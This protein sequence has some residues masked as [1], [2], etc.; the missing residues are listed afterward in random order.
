MADDRPYHKSHARPA[1]EEVDVRFV[2]PLPPPL[3]ESEKERVRAL[4]NA[5]K[6]DL[7]EMIPMIKNLTDEGLI[8]GWRN[9]NIKR[10]K[11]GT[12]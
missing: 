9:V 10:E 6:T 8:H 1:P 12:A 11:N 5:V 2:L 3:S 4:I 7:P